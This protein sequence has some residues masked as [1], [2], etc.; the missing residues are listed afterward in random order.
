MTRSKSFVARFGAC[1][2]IAACL[3]AGSSWS[4]DY[5][6]KPIRVV[7]PVGAGSGLDIVARIAT[8]RL[9]RNLG[10]PIVNDNMAGAGT[11]IGAAAVAR[12]APDGYTLIFWSEAAPLVALSYA[13]L[14]FDPV[15]D[16][17]P[18]GTIAKG[19]FYLSVNPSLPVANVAELVALAKA[20]PGSIAYGS[21]GVGSPHHI[22]TEMFATAAGIKLLH[23]PYKGSGETVTS[24]LRG[25]IQMAMGLPS[26]F[27]PH[28]RSGKFR[29]LA[30]AASERSKEFPNLPTVTESGLKG[31]EYMSW[32][33]L[34]AP[35]ATPQPI[36]AR[37]HAE[38]GKVVADKAY[39][40][41]RLG[42]I[43]LE[44]FAIDSLA[45]TTALSKKYYDM[46]APVARAA[47]IEP[48]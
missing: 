44:P 39:L 42:N 33:A 24:L 7:I 47:G 15:K 18:V 25:D 35:A 22:V 6:S 8:D 31:V 4:Q 32:Y 36:I 30:V 9:A 40:E 11:T 45:E 3:W 19:V 2:T 43:G 5:P 13:K 10:V 48:K 37:L 14:A 34:F 46:L 1:L 29:G 12:A 27:S 38:I 21:S 26:S 41:E 28:L 23:V 17:V 16:F 20:K